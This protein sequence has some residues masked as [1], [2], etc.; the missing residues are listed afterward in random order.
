MKIIC[1]VLGKIYLERLSLRGLKGCPV[2]WFWR[3]WRVLTEVLHEVLQSVKG[4]SHM[5]DLGL[6]QGRK[7]TQQQ[8]HQLCAVLAHLRLGRIRKKT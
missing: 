5:A 8:R 3:R 4:L 7:V 1:C 6:V 2:F